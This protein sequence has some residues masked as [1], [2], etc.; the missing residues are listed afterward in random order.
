MKTYH[1]PPTEG[2]ILPYIPAPPEGS[3]LVA[4][5]AAYGK[6][7]EDLVAELTPAALARMAEMLEATLRLGLVLGMSPHHR[8][9]LLQAT[10]EDLLPDEE[11]RPLERR[12]ARGAVSGDERYK[13]N[14]VNGS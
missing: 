13:W 6:A 5:L 3:E 1:Q 10:L 7:T 14:E 12:A 9:R 11:A 2:G 8:T 4:R